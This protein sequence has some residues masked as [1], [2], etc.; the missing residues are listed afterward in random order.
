MIAMNTRAAPGEPGRR[1]TLA[2]G[3]EHA[4]GRTEDHEVRPHGRDDPEHG[5][6]LVDEREGGQIGVVHVLDAEQQG[7]GHERHQDHHDRRTCPQGQAELLTEVEAGAGKHHEAHA[8]RRDGQ[9]IV[10][11]VGQEQGRDGVEYLA[12][13]LRPG[14]AAGLQDCHGG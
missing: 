2:Q 10:H 1:E 3:E 14:V 11:E 12:V 13:G 8:E 9:S 5:I 4:Q 7:A 6:D